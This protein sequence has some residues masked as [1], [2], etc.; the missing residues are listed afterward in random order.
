MPKDPP[1]GRW[2]F[3]VESPLGTG[4]TATG[5]REVRCNG[6][7]TWFDASLH[8]CPD[9]EHARPGF[10]KHIRTAQLNRHLGEHALHALR[11]PSRAAITSD[12]NLPPAA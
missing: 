9:C 7:R 5:R 1:I 2:G 4:R 12:V 6:C 11:E 10:S 8:R 3:V